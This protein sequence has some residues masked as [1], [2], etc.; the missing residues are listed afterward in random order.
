MLVLIGLYY[1]SFT[2]VVQKV[3]ND[4]KEYAKGNPEREKAYL[5]SV[6]DQPVYP[7]FGHTYQFCKSKELALGLDLKGGMNVTMQVSLRELVR[8]LANNNPD[9]AF[10]QAL[11]K[12]EEAQKTSQKDYITLFVEEYEKAAPS[13]KLAAIF[14]TQ[15]NQANLKFNASNAQV[16]AYL[17]DQANA[18]VKQ[19]YTVLNTRIDQFG[20]AQPNI[21]L[22][23]GTNRIL[24]ELPGVKDPERVRHLLQGSAKLE[25]Y[26]TFDNTE[27][28][29]VLNNVDRLLAAKLKTATPAD[30][31]KAATTAAA[32]DTTKKGDNSLLGKIEKNAKDSAGKNSQLKNNNANPLFSILVPSVYQSAQGMQ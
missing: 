5:D 6:A 4:A 12:A 24:I 27:I 16:K 13:G 26:K 10:N 21:Q 8:S 7:V 22:Q 23:Q 32:N 25:F 29:S 17:Q 3:E 31:A 11:T 14:S 28:H 1:F 30:T 15:D 18:A 9:P 19:A 2:W 20:V